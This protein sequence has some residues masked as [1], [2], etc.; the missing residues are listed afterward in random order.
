MHFV[1]D[2]YVS[3]IGHFLICTAHAESEEK[4][5]KKLGLQQRHGG[6]NEYFLAGVC[7]IYITPVQEVSSNPQLIATASA[8]IMELSEPQKERRNVI[9]GDNRF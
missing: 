4:L 3:E 8:K 9:T 6:C 1:V 2:G 5:A 7:D